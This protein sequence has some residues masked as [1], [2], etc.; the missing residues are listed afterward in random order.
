MKTLS[1]DGS[2]Q[3]E[4]KSTWDHAFS[5]HNT[6][7]GRSKL[8]KSHSG[9]EHKCKVKAIHLIRPVGKRILFTM[10]DSGQAN[11]SGSGSRGWHQRNS[12]KEKKKIIMQ[13]FKLSSEN[14]GEAKSQA[15][16]RELG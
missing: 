14:S 13:L 15:G 1:D 11:R 5:S 6:S 2:Q 7:S 9:I 12:N 10:L 8:R 3:G 16:G 4:E